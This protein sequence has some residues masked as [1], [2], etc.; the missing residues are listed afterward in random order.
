MFYLAWPA[1]DFLSCSLT[2]KQLQD[3][4]DDGQNQKYVNR[5]SRSVID[6]KAAYPSAHQHER[7][8]QPNESHFSPR[9]RKTTYFEEFLLVIG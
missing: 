3:D 7:Q 6:N 2:T 8:Q 4:R 1:F 9:L 5:E